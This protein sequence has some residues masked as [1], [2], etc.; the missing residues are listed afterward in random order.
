MRALLAGLV[1]IV[2]LSGCQQKRTACIF[3]IPEGFTGWVL[4]EFGR[5]NCPPLAKRDGKLIF[6]IGHD[7]RL[8]TSSAQ[9]FGWAKDAYFYVG[10]S[11]TAIPGTVSGGG[12]LI[13]GGSTGSTQTG[14]VERVYESFF[15]GTEDQF[16]HAAEHPTP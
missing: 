3:E 11:R 2:V 8:C 14:S 5:T 12:G 4:I 15:I 9:E 1:F 7:G 13:W 6:E 16:T 10:K